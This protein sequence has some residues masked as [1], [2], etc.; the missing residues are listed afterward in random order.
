M[1]RHEDDRRLIAAAQADPAAFRAIVELYYDPV[2]RCCALRTGDAGAATAWA[3][4]VFAR[5]QT[6]VQRYRWDG[7][8]LLAWLFSQARA[9]AAPQPQPPEAETAAA[10]AD[11]AR[12]CVE[13]RRL[14]GRVDAATAEALVL[15]FT[16]GYSFEEI[17]TLHDSSPESAKI[18]IYRAVVK[19]CRASAGD[20]EG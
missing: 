3:A 10:R 2:F 15:Y 16:T 4:A 13:A 5:A 20:D 9:L 18:R 12:A 19:A 1:I 8:P 14:L 6:E 17:A 7:R 11:L